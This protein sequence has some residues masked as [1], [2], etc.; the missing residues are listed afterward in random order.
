MIL[1][2]PLRWPLGRERTH[3]RQPARFREGTSGA[4]TLSFDTA[5]AR[6]A[7]QF[8]RLRALYPSL[9]TD[10]RHNRDGSRDRT[11][12]GSTRPADPGAAVTFRLD[13]RDYELAC[14]RWDSAAGNVAAI[15]AH[16]DALRGQERWGVAD[17]RQAFAGHIALPAPEPWWTVLGVSRDAP[18]AVVKAAFRALAKDAHPD[19]G[20]DRATWDRLNA[21][22]QAGTKGAEA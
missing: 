5:V 15:A 4:G 3:E 14:D 21:A 8:E 22:Y 17:L 20:G 12:K 2:Y 10:V 9:W 6:L 19:Q 1:T 7:Y 13:G 18:P 11:A 16:I